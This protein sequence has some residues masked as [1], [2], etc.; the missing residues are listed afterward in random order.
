MRQLGQAR[1]CSELL[2]LES[3]EIVQA[4]AGRLL[5]ALMFERSYLAAIEAGAAQPMR[6]EPQQIF[7][8]KGGWL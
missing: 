4:S 1:E 5:R 8:K 7:R 2:M 6:E 3:H